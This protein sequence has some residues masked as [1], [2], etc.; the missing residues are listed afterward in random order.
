MIVDNIFESGYA[1]N[2]ERAIA[3][4]MSRAVDSQDA[5][6]VPEGMMDFMKPK[7]PVD[8]KE[9][10]SLAVMRQ[11]EKERAAKDRQHPTYTRSIDLPKNPDH[12]RTVV[13]EFAPGSG[14]GESGQWYTDDQITDIVGDGWWDDLDVS[15]DISK[16]EMI[17]QA[18]AWLDDQGYSVH[19]LNCK[20]ND[21][22]MEWFIEGNFHNPRFANEGVAE[23]GYQH[24]FADPNAPR[25]GRKPS[26]DVSGE[27]EPA[28][29][30]MVVI[31]GRDWKEFTSNR[32]FSVAKTIATKDPN[33]KVQVRW[34]T[35]QLNTVKEGADDPWGSQ[36]R[37]V[38]DTGPT[39]ISTTVPQVQ[40]QPGDQV[41]YK[42][43]EQRARIEGLSQDRTQA[44]IYI[45]S[46]M[47]GKYFD[48][49]TSD[50]KALGRG[51]AEVAPPGA[52]AERMVKHIKA[53]Y[54]KDGK[55][56][57]V[58][59]RKA[60][61]AA[62]KAHNKDLVEGLSTML[63]NAT[64]RNDLRQIRNFVTEHVSDKNKQRQIM[65]QATRIVAVQRR[66]YAALSAK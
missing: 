51:I 66:K 5:E 54:A 16:Q 6:G 47:G 3:R 48:C 52:K 55:L 62:W 45:A 53:G 11:I 50:L 26:A 46:G 1:G 65:E 32:A 7:T 42:P 12:M 40:L 15:G 61:G 49:K 17:Q 2:T 60:F 23:A 25:L 9:K 21:D 28:G 29:M 58:E 33:K 20:L 4:N 37:F 8:S 30:F 35:G 44:R 56:T 10:L 43:T 24:G 57:D 36:G 63:A 59:K 27:G 31:N 13:D 39:Q 19:V 22:D 34:P 64:S 14:G 41:I 38:G 18:Q